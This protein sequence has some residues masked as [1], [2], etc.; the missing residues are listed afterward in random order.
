MIRRPLLKDHVSLINKNWIL[1][2]CQDKDFA[3]IHSV[4]ETSAI[5]H[6][7]GADHNHNG[8]SECAFPWHSNPRNK[9]YPLDTYQTIESTFK[10][11]MAHFS[12]LKLI[13]SA[14]RAVHAGLGCAQQKLPS[15][16]V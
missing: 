4:D 7:L 15:L 1:L 12:L 3:F 9:E 6:L 11:I 2:S 14:C 13:K 16:Y 10:R 5:V 8:V